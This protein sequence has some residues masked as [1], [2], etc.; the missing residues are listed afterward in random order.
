[1]SLD[2]HRA[3]LQHDIEPWDRENG[4]DGVLRGL[5]PF[6]DREPRTASL[7]YYRYEIT[8]MEGTSDFLCLFMVCRLVRWAPDGSI[9]DVVEQPVLI[10]D[11]I[12][13]EAYDTTSHVIGTGE[14]ESDFAAHITALVR[15]M[16]A[17]ARVRMTAIDDAST[18]ASLLTDDAWLNA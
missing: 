16:V 13:D 3:F 17:L 9:A 14:S 6:H 18:P 10:G 11:L 15:E 12:E 8:P 5:F 2:R 7:E 1:M 4:L